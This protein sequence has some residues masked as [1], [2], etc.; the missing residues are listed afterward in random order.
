MDSIE[1]LF[2]EI[3]K[4]SHPPV[5]T[6]TPPTTR[7]VDI[8]I[9]RRG[10][11]FYQGSRIQRPEMVRLF[12][13]VLLL[14]EDQYALVTPVERLYIEVE[15]VPFVAGSHQVVSQNGIDYHVFES[16]VGE[17]VIVNE[18]HPRTVRDTPG[19][20]GVVPYLTIRDNLQARLTRA[21]YYRV[22]EYCVEYHG[23]LGVW[24]A[25][26]FFPLSTGD[27]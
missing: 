5:H 25:E 13:S 21:D 4:Q 22:A 11:W 27:E 20:E 1:Q 7:H 2:E 23:R 24:S 9:D 16:N 19:A 3:G 15:D 17:R 10:E 12:S 26:Q 6:W 18:L 14:E 8:R